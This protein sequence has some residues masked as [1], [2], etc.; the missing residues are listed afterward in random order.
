[1]ANFQAE[2]EGKIRRKEAELAALEAQLREVRTYLTALQ[3]MRRMMDKAGSANASSTVGSRGIRE[4][5]TVH[6][7][8][9]ILREAGHPLHISE[10]LKR[11]GKPNT[12]DAGAAVTGSLSSYVRRGQI[13]TRPK[14]GTFGL[15]EMIGDET[16][17][18][19]A[20]IHQLRL[21]GSR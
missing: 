15:V 6:R 19:S 17:Q 2:L 1:M 16:D 4:G 9:E 7:A 3:D 21:E 12:R 8:L 14:P 11:L 13:F 10:L 5:T 18:P 20:A